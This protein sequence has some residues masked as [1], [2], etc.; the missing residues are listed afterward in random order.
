MVDVQ[1]WPS[2]WPVVFSCT[3][4]QLSTKSSGGSSYFHHIFFPA[5]KAKN[6]SEHSRIPWTTNTTVLGWWTAD[7]NTNFRTTTTITFLDFRIPSKPLHL[8]EDVIFTDILPLLKKGMVCVCHLN[9]DRYS[10]TGS[11]QTWRNDT[12]PIRSREHFSTI[13][14]YKLTSLHSNPIIPPCEGRSASRIDSARVVPNGNRHHLTMCF[15]AAPLFKKKKRSCGL[16]WKDLESEI[17]WKCIWVHLCL[18]F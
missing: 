17:F 3:N 10:V 7:I 4:Q 11:P 9:L 13:I 14:I 5:F 16:H 18:D 2:I 8:G 15:N 12:L 1:V 6:S